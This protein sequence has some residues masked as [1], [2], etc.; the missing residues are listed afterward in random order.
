[1]LKIFDL[2]GISQCWDG[3]LMPNN[4]NVIL[5]LN[6]IILFYGSSDSPSSFMRIKF[7]KRIDPF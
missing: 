4:N 5:T 7:G 6:F 1:M 3:I 2:D